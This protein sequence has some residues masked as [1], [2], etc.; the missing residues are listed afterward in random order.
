MCAPPAASAATASVHAGKVHR[1]MA[2][3]DAVSARAG[4]AAG[5]RDRGGAAQSRRIYRELR[6]KRL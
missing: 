6:L 3:G 4:C 1:I 2:S 5:A